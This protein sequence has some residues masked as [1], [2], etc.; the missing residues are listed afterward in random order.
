M[1]RYRGTVRAR[2]SAPSDAARARPERPAP[3]VWPLVAVTLAV[4]AIAYL[5]VLRFYSFGGQLETD[6]MSEAAADTRVRIEL[7]SVD[8]AAH[9]ATIRLHLQSASEDVVRSDRR[10]AR[11]IRIVVS[12]N[13]GADEFTFPRG[14][15]LTT[16]E[17][18]VGITGETAAYPFDEH[19]SRVGIE[20]FAVETSADGEEILTEAI[21]V[22]L[23]VSG[24]VN[25]WDSRAST[26]QAAGGVGLMDVT[27]G[28]AFSTQ[29]FAIL[30]VCMALVVAL[31]PF[32]VGVSA[33]AGKHDVD[34]SL[35][36]W[37]AGLLF[38]LVAL[39]FYLPGDPPVGSGIDVFAYLWITVIA[40]L[41]LF[42]LVHSWMRTHLHVRS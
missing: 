38:A 30:L 13:D 36:G 40:F 41:G 11:D 23:T 31:F 35:L 19:A 20:V 4:M 16:A 39:R 33:L 37:A 26:L 24:G 42:A 27:F 10:L 12:A 9:A 7:V 29:F 18:I 8:T 2:G 17:D 25:G 32:T 15:L 34:S 28:R 3:R 22:D 6:Q 14:S 5:L 21:P 1:R